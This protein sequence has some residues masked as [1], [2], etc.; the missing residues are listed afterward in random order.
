M[1]ESNENKQEQEE[2]NEEEEVKGPVTIFNSIKIP[3]LS[4]EYVP[5]FQMQGPEIEVSY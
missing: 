5:D 1:V 2:N 3:D 4:K